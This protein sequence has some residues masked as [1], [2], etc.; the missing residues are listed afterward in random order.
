M[1]T[2]RILS[3]V[4]AG[5]IASSYSGLNVFASGDMSTEDYA[6]SFY[7]NSFYVET[8]Q[9]IEN[10]DNTSTS[11]DYTETETSYNTF[12]TYSE[13]IEYTDI[14][15][16]NPATDT[17]SSCEDESVI[18]WSA[19]TENNTTTESN[20]VTDN[21]KKGTLLGSATIYSD[22]T[23]TNSWKNITHSADMLNGFEL[24][25]WEEFSFYRYFP[26]HCGYEEGFVDAP[27]YTESGTAP[28]GGIC[29][30][31]TGTYKC[32]VLVC[33]LYEVER[34]DHEKP[35]GYAVKGQDAAVNLDEDITYRQD[36]RFINDTEHTLK[37]Y[38]DYN[39]WT[40]EFT[41]SCYIVD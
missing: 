3:A 23:F 8:P 33:G 1:K 34:H 31:S 26:G 18:E 17:D 11:S 14:V 40:G 24:K 25:P 22:K 12:D 37:F 28:G 32:A 4:V 41:V 29:F 2:N 35:V 9:Y 38:Y 27:A 20:V 21:T 30:T 6:Y 19:T 10:L 15:E 16:Y 7:D 5:A 13:D 36:M 39:S